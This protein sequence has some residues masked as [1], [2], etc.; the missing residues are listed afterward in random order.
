MKS[1]KWANT[2]ADT[3]DHLQLLLLRFMRFRQRDG[4]VPLPA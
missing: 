1:L 2:T 3:G 4:R